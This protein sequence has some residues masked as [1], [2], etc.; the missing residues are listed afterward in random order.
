[1][2]LIIAKQSGL[3]RI[4]YINAD[5]INSFHADKNEYDNRDETKIYFTEGKSV[6]EGNMAKR[7]AT[8]MSN[9]SECGILDLTKEQETA[10]KLFWDKKGGLT[11]E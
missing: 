6:I 8:F 11:N 7:I 9:D 10:K 5:R 4:A 3:E 2:K 1:M